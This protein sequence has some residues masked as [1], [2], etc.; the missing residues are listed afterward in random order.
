MSKVTYQLPPTFLKFLCEFIFIH[1]SSYIIFGAKEWL[2]LMGWRIFL[3]K[4]YFFLFLRFNLHNSRKSTSWSFHVR[5]HSVPLW[6]EKKEQV[7]REG[8]SWKGKWTGSR[9]EKGAWSSIGWGKKIEAH[10]ISYLNVITRHPS[11]L[12]VHIYSL[13]NEH[14]MT[15]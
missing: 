12:N 13:N 7:G 15:E 9:E 6:R 3:P 5:T 10:W 4:I 11:V 1:C 2:A 8:G 14:K